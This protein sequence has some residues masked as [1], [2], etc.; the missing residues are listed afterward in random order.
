[1]PWRSTAKWNLATFVA[2]TEAWPVRQRLA[3]LG[4]DRAILV[5]EILQQIEA[6]WG[7]ASMKRVVNVP[8]FARAGLKC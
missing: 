6:H 5:M 8:I 4:S 3:R 1:M 7:K 2:Q